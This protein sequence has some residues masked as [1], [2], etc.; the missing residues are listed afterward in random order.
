MA[1]PDPRPNTRPPDSQQA[2]RTDQRDH[3]DPRAEPNRHAQEENEAQRVRAILF[4]DEVLAPPP[5]IP[6]YHTIWLSTTNAYDSIERRRK[7]GYVPVKREELPNADFGTMHAGSYAG[8]ITQAEFILFKLP[9]KTYAAIMELLHHTRPLEE[10][11][12]I[13]ANVDALASQSN[14]II[15]NKGERD[16]G[17]SRMG[18]FNPRPRFDLNA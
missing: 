18:K 11:R 9:Q 6:G 10:E 13:R 4:A 15:D 12:G 5:K 3:Q 1:Q 7:V 16:T 17:F 8:C 2:S 14:V